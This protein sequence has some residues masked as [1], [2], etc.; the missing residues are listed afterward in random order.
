MSQPRKYIIAIEAENKPGV[1]SKILASCRRRRFNIESVSASPTHKPNLSYI[2]L[3]I[4]GG[5]LHQIINQINRVI[6]VTHIQ[7]L[8]D[9]DLIDR[10]IALVKFKKRT[11]L[12]SSLRSLDK[13]VK[14]NL[15]KINS[16]TLE[17]SGR[18]QDVSEIIDYLE[19]PKIAVTAR[20]GL[21][22]IKE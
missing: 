11:D 20:T 15:I 14:V 16:Q 5:R 1:L 18:G 9:P 2:T 3:V 19:A 21:T 4:I 12:T 10:E 8:K 22:A 17:I 7:E 13:F 6:E